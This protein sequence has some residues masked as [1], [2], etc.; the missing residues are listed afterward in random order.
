[1]YIGAQTL[2]CGEN[3][4]PEDVTPLGDCRS[5][6][7]TC[8]PGFDCRESSGGG[9][10]CER[11]ADA[12]SDERQDATQPDVDSGPK[13]GPGEPCKS[14]VECLSDTCG[15]A[16]G[17]FCVEVCTS[18]A[19]CSDS[20]TCVLAP[21]GQ[22]AC[23]PRCSNDGDC[24]TDWI[25]APQE[26]RSSVCRPHCEL[27]PCPRGFECEA[28][29]GLCVDPGCVPE[30]EVCN[31]R[32]DDCDGANDES[33]TNACGT[34]G[35]PPAERCDGDDDDCDGTTDEGVTNA[36]GTCGAVPREVCNES[37]DDCDGTADEGLSNACGGCGPLPAEICDGIDQDC[38]GE[39]DNNAACPAGEVCRNGACRSQSPAA[40]PCGSDDDCSVG[41]CERGLPGGFCELNCATD[42]D[43]GPSAACAPNGG[44]NVCRELCMGGCRAGW[45]CS[46]V[47]NENGVCTPS[48]NADSDCDIGYSCEPSGRCE[49]AVA[50]IQLIRAYISLADQ[51]GVEW[52]GFGA[53][54]PAVIRQAANLAAAA[55]G[56]PG[57]GELIARFVGFLSGAWA[58]PDPGGGANVLVNGSGLGAIRLVQLEDTYIPD[59]GQL[60]VVWPFVALDP[61]SGAQLQLS[62]EDGDFNAN[63][64]MGTVVIGREDLYR[65]MLEAA[66]YAVPVGDQGTSILSVVINVTKAA[67]PQ[68]CAPGCE[69]GWPG[70]GECDA[71][72]NNADCN[73]DANDCAELPPLECALGCEAGWPGD[74]I[75]DDVCD[76]EACGFDLGDCAA[77]SPAGPCVDNADCAFGACAPSAPG[78]FCAVDCVMDAECGPEAQ[79]ISF[80][81]G[82]LCVERCA[83]VCRPGWVCYEQPNADGACFPACNGDA[84]C[85]ADSVCDPSG[86]CVA[87]EQECAPGCP[88][89]WLGD[90]EC[91]AACNVPACSFDLRDC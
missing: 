5:A 32:D 50:R 85:G 12:G 77:S 71:A 72:C 39:P 81:D 11:V 52:D 83:G 31:G 49:V 51:R 28:S 24:R 7:A 61:Q 56:V 30:A 15:S 34:C 58:P 47:A 16:P 78:G 4:E 68:Q 74:G 42:D 75:C 27:E 62:L 57:A 66:P 46:A 40:G 17:G 29:T 82:N 38:N 6:A 37:D 86:F 21:G 18:D 20:T 8:A 90:G 19:D 3:A 26:R 76:V 63:D 89:A 54:D 45:T 65:A 80:A 10:A 87:Q 14:D 70:D 9:W 35:D 91:D 79:C 1:M 44:S 53:V 55:V 13:S 43:C 23:L 73:F 60:Q 48:C 36:C 25:C 33:V 67:R 59:W 2:G 84:D 69:A 22:M 88:L 41:T 64:Q